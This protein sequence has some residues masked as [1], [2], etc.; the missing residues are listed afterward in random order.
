MTTSRLRRLAV[1][2]SLSLALGASAACGSSERSAPALD[3]A[4]PDVA[5]AFDA[6]PPDDAADASGD[7][8]VADASAD[9]DAGLPPPCGDGVLQG[10]QECEDGNGVGGDGCDDRCHLEPGWEC[11][12]LGAACNR[13][14]CGDGQKR[15]TEDCD[16]GNADWGDTCTPVCTLAPS[17]A[18]GVCTAICG[19]GIVDATEACDDGNN[20][21][22]DGCSPTCTVEPGFE[23]TSAPGATV[24]LPIVHRDFR[25]YDL[26]AVADLPQGHI[27]FQNASGAETGIVLAT[28]GPNGKPAYAKD[29]V[30]SATT[31]GKTAF[32]QWFR[33]VDKVNLRVVQKLPLA[34][35]V[36]SGSYRFDAN[37]YFPVDGV[38]FPAVGREPTR[39][40]G[41]GTQ[42]NFSF[43]SEL[44][45]WI[46]YAGTEV[47][48]VSGDDD[49]WLFVNGRLAI[50]LGGVHSAQFATVTL[51][52]KAGALGLT[53]NGR[54]E[55]AIFRAERLTSGSSFRLD[56]PPPLAPSVCT[57]VP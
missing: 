26:P 40:D 47:I 44:R 14:V 29:G 17:C 25:G 34:R 31:H 7:V 36:P 24:D 20:R 12:T 13:T 53:V 41:S 1:A 6:S 48:Q 37:A 3:D 32:D 2:L 39:G 28:L 35:Q 8:A 45:F 52:Q 43:T 5:P 33:D 56:L 42:R 46:T 4:G 57:P 11:P 23:C 54:Y 22:F 9:A 30:S 18:N 49:I 55:V 51:S 16:D 15:G 50:D 27:D 10:D 19:D 38:G 21:P